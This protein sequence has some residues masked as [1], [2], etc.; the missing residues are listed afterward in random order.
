[1]KIKNINI[2]Y[3]VCALTMPVLAEANY[4]DLEDAFYKAGT[5]SKEE[6]VGWM[7]GRCFP[8]NNPYHSENSLLVG[9][10][11]RYSND[12]PAFGGTHHFMMWHA[13]N[14]GPTYYDYMSS[15]EIAGVKRVVNWVFNNTQNPS[16]Q[17]DGSLTVHFYSDYTHNGRNHY[18]SNSVYSLRKGSVAGSKTSYLIA[19]LDLKNL[20]S[21]Y[22]YQFEQI[23]SYY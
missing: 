21:K 23:R 6:V 14:Y 16:R 13:I 4:Y 19:K 10:P 5:V 12:G 22:C 3:L 9:S 8:A 15:R 20:P 17:S 7:G 1:M 2:M 18:V 11:V